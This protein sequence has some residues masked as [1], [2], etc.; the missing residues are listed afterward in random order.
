MSNR[1]VSI[2]GWLILLVTVTAMAGC[3]NDGD[4]HQGSLAGR[5]ES[6]ALRQDSQGTSGQDVRSGTDTARGRLWVLGLGDV[7][8]Y[9]TAK[10][11]LIAKI[12]LPNW[13]VFGKTCMPDMVLDRSGSAFISS[14]VMAKLWRI[15]ADSFEVREHEITMQG[16][17]HWDIGWGAM[18]FTSNGTLYA[19]TSTADSL[20]Q[21]DVAKASASMIEAYHPPLKGCAFSKQFRDRLER[22][23]KS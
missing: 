12:T 1:I 5:A 13:Y 19:L 4:T 6:A 11:N 15:D 8:V 23:P 2:R 17:E 20:W 10:R 3:G 22:S 9:D 14:N 16:R 21:I 18:V 7:R